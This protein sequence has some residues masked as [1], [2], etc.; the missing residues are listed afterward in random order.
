MAEIRK[1]FICGQSYEYC[2]NCNNAAEPWKFLYDTEECVEVAEVWYAYRGK[3]ITKEE[4]KA[5]LDKHP[6]IIALVL[7]ND[8]TPANEIQEIY[9]VEIVKK[10]EPEVVE[11]TTEEKPVEV[12]PVE[13]PKMEKK[14]FGKNFKK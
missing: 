3:E 8:S 11:E 2:P 12:K 4:A 7:K 9:G 10:I 6:S 13:E 14:S 5:K 1:C